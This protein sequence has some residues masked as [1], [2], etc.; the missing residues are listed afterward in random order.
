MTVKMF[1]WN[2]TVYAIHKATDELYASLNGH[3]DQFVEV[4]LGKRSGSRI[5]V[6]SRSILSLP[7][8]T[9][10]HVIKREVEGYKSFIIGLPLNGREDTDL[11]NIRDA[12]LGDLN[13]FLY[14][15]SFS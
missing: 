11:A 1:H 12:I 5:P 4:L 13:R 3:V 8:I 10:L 15:L 2:T 14:L 9:S 6:T 7:T